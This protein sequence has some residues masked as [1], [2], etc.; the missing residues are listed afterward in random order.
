MGKDLIKVVAKKEAVQLGHDGKNTLLV[1]IG[2]VGN[3]NAVA[4]VPA[5]YLKEFSN[6]IREYV[7]QI[8]GPK[9]QAA[10]DRDNPNKENS[11]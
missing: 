11:N 4:A 10:K 9:I 3:E 8:D 1:P 7:P 5:F 6:Y 2:A